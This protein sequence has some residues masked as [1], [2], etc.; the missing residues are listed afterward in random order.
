VVRVGVSLVLRKKIQLHNLFRWVMIDNDYLG[1][2]E[3]FKFPLALQKL[4]LFTMDVH[5]RHKPKSR[6]K[7]LVMC[8][9]DQKRGKSLVLA[10]MATQRET[11][12]RNDFKFRFK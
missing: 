5:Q 4:G 3:L 12:N 10:V 8:V 7:P 9:T 1:D 2:I 11:N 6:A